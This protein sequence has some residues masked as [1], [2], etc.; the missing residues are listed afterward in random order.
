M[1]F[2]II[3][4][5]IHLYTAASIPRLSWTDDLVDDHVLNRA[6][7][8]RDY[9][10]ATAKTKNLLGFVFLETDRKS[11]LREDQW[12]DA[13]DEVRFLAR[14]AQGK[15]RPGE[16]HEVEDSKLVFGIV[17]WAPIPV[18][19]IKL[20]K[21]VDKVLQAFPDDRK[22]LVK[23]FRYL[24]Q[25]KSPRTMLQPDFVDSLHW[26]GEHSFSFDLGIDARSAGLPQLQ[27]ACALL[28]RL[29]ERGSEVNVV[30]N[31]FCKPNLRLSNS[32]EVSD[33][34]DFRRWKV[35]IENMASFKST[36][37]KLSGFFSEL[38]P[39]TPSNPAAISTLV[40]QLQPWIDAVFQAFTPSR[41]LFGSDWPVCNVGG[42]G[43]DD[44][45]QHWHDLVTAI[46]DTLNL[47]NEEKAMIW[48]G[49]AAEAYKI[50]LTTK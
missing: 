1:A 21:Y 26:L 48:A 10:A 17:P 33:H 16:G 50:P 35:M 29:H 37:M 39:Q 18:G 34:L 36:Y 40:N 42:P 20:A 46:L 41:I 5:H 38:H 11:G 44:S 28:E 25:D 49:T 6:N 7:T 23:G 45:F 12:N 15:P 22:Y 43:R 24:L 14:I 8:V 3:D 31:H 2:P 27:E 13:I 47:T 32:D 9:K 4:S 30:V 19:P